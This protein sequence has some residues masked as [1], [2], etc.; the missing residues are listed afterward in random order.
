MSIREISQSLGKTLENID[1]PEPVR[2]VYNPVHYAWKSHEMYLERF[3][4]STKEVLFLGI[5]PGPFGMAQTGVPFGEVSSVRD[6]MGIEA[7]VKKPPI[8]HPKRPIIGFACERS[9]V[10]GRR[11]W[12]WA[13]ERFGTAENFFDRFFVWNYCPLSFMIETGA[14]FTPDKFP[15]ELKDTI[16]SHC[17]DALRALVKELDPE[18]VIGVGK[19]AESR[20]KEAL[21]NELYKI[22][23]ILHPSPASP[24]ANRGWSEAAEKQLSAMGIHF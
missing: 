10:S 12:G 1:Y 14:N 20:A 11:L 15:V 8:E 18:W 6:W 7:P 22:G 2:Y 24:A 3:S 23:T 17:D 13:Q 9:E 4:S 19:F 5:N 16:F 21:G